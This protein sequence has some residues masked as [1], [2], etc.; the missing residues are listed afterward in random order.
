MSRYYMRSA[1]AICPP[2]SA[3]TRK[4]RDLEGHGRASAREAEPVTHVDLTCHLVMTLWDGPTYCAALL[5]RRTIKTRACFGT[6]EIRAG[7]LLLSEPA[8]KELKFAKTLNWGSL[9]DAGRVHVRCTAP[10]SEL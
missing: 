9:T 5:A 10:L 4:P 3:I 2:R 6:W 1:E 8:V 7:E